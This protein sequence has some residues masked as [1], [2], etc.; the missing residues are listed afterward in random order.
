MKPIISPINAT[1]QS[2]H[3]RAV[4]RSSSIVC[5]KTQGHA[6]LQGRV[7]HSG[8]GTGAR[9]TPSSAPARV[10]VAER[11]QE[12]DGNSAIIEDTKHCIV[13]LCLW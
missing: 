10:K 12:Q 9:A 13:V 6:S 4:V 5:S 11:V 3:P 2:T 7:S 8:V 1:A